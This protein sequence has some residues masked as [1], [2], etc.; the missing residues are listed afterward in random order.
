MA[1]SFCGAGRTAQ[2]ASWSFPRS[3][4]GAR[5]LGTLPIRILRRDELRSDT[6]LAAV[7][8]SF[9]VHQ[10]ISPKTEEFY[11]THFKSYVTYLAATL[12]REPVLDDVD[13]DYAAMFI[14]KLERE[15]T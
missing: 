4:N 7:M 15:P 6:P 10:S 8:E 12:G 14:K 2:N 1:R 5:E 11:R 13:P 3:G 9:F